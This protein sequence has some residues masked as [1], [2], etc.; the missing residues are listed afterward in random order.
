M[1]A[2]SPGA[3]GRRVSSAGERPPCSATGRFRERG[4]GAGT[5]RLARLLPTRPWTSPSGP[6]LAEGEDRQGETATERGAG[7]RRTERSRGEETPLEAERERER[8]SAAGRTGE[9]TSGPSRARSRSAARGR[10]ARPLT[11][12][13]PA[14]TAPSRPPRASSCSKKLRAASKLR[15]MALPASDARST[16][17][18]PRSHLV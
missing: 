14:R 3:A 6:L 16:C 9:Q 17:G 12:N 11:L 4:E 10:P 8:Q 13:S 18:V 2:W 7:E 5:R 15:L 1:A